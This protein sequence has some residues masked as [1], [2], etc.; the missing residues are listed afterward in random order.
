V[1]IAVVLRL[2]D[3]SAR[4]VGAL[5]QALPDRH[6]D[7]S[8]PHIKLASYDDGTDTARLDDALAEVVRFCGW[9]TISLT[10][11]GVVPGL[12]F[13]L[14]LLPVPITGLLRLHTAVDEALFRI[15]DRHCDEFGSW[16]P[17]LML[18]PT[19]FPA[20]AMEVLTS[21]WNGPIEAVLERIEIVRLSPFTVISSRMLPE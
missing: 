11:I 7:R 5:I 16:S 6:F 21:M 8:P 14:S 20:D 10:A 19:A 9:M 17:S 1:T 2:D 13:E 12:R 3:D 4:R 18:G 15:V